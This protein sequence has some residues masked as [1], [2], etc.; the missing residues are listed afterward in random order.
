MDTSF[1]SN[2][3][4]LAVAVAALAYFMLGALWYSFLFRNLWIKSSGVDMSNPD[5]KKGVAAT[6]VLTLLLEFVIC[7]GIA[8]LVYRLGLIGGVMSGVK[9]G[10]L[11]G[12]VFCSPVMFINNLYQ[13]KPIQ[14]GLIDSGYH[15]VGNVIAAIILC[16]W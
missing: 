1:F 13:G 3:N 8:I 2:I 11:T 9:L 12:A 7:I 14:L 4:W 16:I 6:M 10:L 15:I 5:A